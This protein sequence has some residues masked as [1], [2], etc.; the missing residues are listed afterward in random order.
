MRLA[1]AAVAVLAAALLAATAAT[2]LAPA[3]DATSY[4]YWI[5]WHYTGGSW[6]YSQVGPR[7]DRMEDGDVAGWRFGRSAASSSALNPRRSGDYATLCPGHPT[8]DD[9][10]QVALV[11]DYG[12]E[13]DAPGYPTATYCLT[14]GSHHQGTDALRATGLSLRSD[15]GS[16]LCAIH[17][18]PK[19]PECGKTVDGP[20]P[21]QKPTPRTSTATTPPAQPAGSGPHSPSGSQASPA[22]G[23]PASS[24]PPAR[25][26]TRPNV[27][28]LPSALASVT[29][30]PEGTVAQDGVGSDGPPSKDRKLPTG[31]LAGG[32]LVAALGGAAAVRARR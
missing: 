15:G 4:R 16:L 2:G 14:L 11:I 23:S 25:I 28:R 24:S 30:T 7:D 6:H 8:T 13:A 29:A 5:Y 19:P 26:V 31:L 12:T 21:T 20:A 17:D 22:A 32:L 27:T 18:Y 1:R 9:G 10:T 3:A